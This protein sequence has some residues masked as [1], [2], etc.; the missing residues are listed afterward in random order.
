MEVNIKVDEAYVLY[1][2][3]SLHLHDAKK[4]VCANL[5][6]QLTFMQTF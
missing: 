5:T 1:V 4:I 2:Y 6:E 3:H